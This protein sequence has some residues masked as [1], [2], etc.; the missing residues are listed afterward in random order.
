VTS[1]TTADCDITHDRRREISV[2]P[3]EKFSATATMRQLVG[4]RIIV[5]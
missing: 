1:R 4:E 2:G 3:G 5:A